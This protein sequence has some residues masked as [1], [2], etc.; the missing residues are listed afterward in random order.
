MR[1]S[2]ISDSGCP[3]LSISS[4]GYSADITVTRFGPGV[5]NSYIV[6]YVLSGKGYF[7]GVPVS[8][9]QGFLITPNMPEYY[10]PDENDPW[11]FLWI[12][13]DDPRVADLFEM[14]N[15]DRQTHIFRY[16][17]LSAAR[18]TASFFITN[19]NALLNGYEMLEIL[20]KLFKNQHREKTHLLRSNADVYIEAARKYI[21]TNLQNP[22]TVSEITDFLGITQPY[23]FRLFKERFSLSPKQYILDRKLTRALNLLADSSLSVTH[24]AN[25]V[26]FPDVM[27]FSKCFKTKMGVSP[28][29]YRKTLTTGG[30]LP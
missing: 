4:M 14:L 27:T 26:G 29:N 19:N 6:H 16:N 12:I 23:L 20:L 24:I 28:Q 7:N 21:D 18:E 22:V 9:G 17:Y 5:R 8:A 11:E 25:S 10:Y 13:S 15:A 3:L 2:I 1:Y 30:P